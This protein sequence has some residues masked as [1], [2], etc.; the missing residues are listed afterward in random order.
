MIFLIIIIF[1]KIII[2]IGLIKLLYETKKPFLCSAIYAICQIFILSLLPESEFSLILISSVFSFF[3]AS[4]YFW[5]LNKFEEADLIYW[6]VLII[7][8][9]LF[10]I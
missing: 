3:L 4:I 5:L 10:F 1:I 2:L 9:I 7:G 8:G 6:I